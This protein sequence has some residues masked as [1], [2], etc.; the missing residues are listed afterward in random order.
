MP[1]PT[2]TLARLC[3]NVAI[4]TGGTGEMGAAIAQRFFEEGAV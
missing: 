1:T 2:K 4:L 3:D